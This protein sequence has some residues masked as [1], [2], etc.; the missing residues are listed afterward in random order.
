M[1]ESTTRT[2]NLKFFSC[3]FISFAFKW[4]SRWW[5]ASRRKWKGISFGWCLAIV[6]VCTVHTQLKAQWTQ[7][8]GS[9]WFLVSFG[10]V[11]GLKF[12]SLLQAR[13][14]WWNW[15]EF[16]KWPSGE[17]GTKKYCI[18][19]TCTV[20]AHTQ[21]MPFRIVIWFRM[22]AGYCCEDHCVD[23]FH[24]NCY[25]FGCSFHLTRTP[26]PEWLHS[27]L[28]EKWTMEHGQR[29]RSEEEE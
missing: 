17:A 13:P 26:K 21:H 4:L 15:S 16:S 8:C 10:H 11:F 29:V 28:I 3:F 18:L 19:H 22:E 7:R 1:S 20:H 12:S 5:I 23:S 25:S 14:G 24:W 27:R 2:N 9:F 6:S